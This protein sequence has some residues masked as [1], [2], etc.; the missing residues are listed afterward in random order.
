MAN[1]DLFFVSVCLFVC[2]SCNAW[3]W[4][5][6]CRHTFKR[7]AII[8]DSLIK[9]LHVY[10]NAFKV[11]RISAFKTEIQL[12]LNTTKTCF[13]LINLSY[14][15]WQ[16]KEI[17]SSFYQNDTPPMHVMAKMTLY[18]LT[19]IFSGFLYRL[20]HV[21]IKRWAKPVT[22]DTAPIIQNRLLING[23][24][25]NQENTNIVK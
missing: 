20:Q 16:G 15:G 4:I 6:V 1:H 10:D 21:I 24:Q 23:M 7:N 18:F 2:F 8:C 14:T 11:S 5:D 12:K 9:S 13:V 22:Y 19:W 17:A 3:T 25:W